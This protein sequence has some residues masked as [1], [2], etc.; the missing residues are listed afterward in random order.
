MNTAIIISVISL[1][2]SVLAVA[3]SFW[4]VK[5]LNDKENDRK[6]EKKKANWKVERI[7]ITGMKSP[8][9]VLT[10][11]NTGKAVAT[12]IKIFVN[13]E[14]INLCSYV[15]SDVSIIP[16]IGSGSNYVIALSVYDGVHFPWE[17]KIV[18]DD[19]YKSE[20]EYITSVS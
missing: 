13:K 1:F 19:D 8:K 11:E 10:I 6:E 4:R 7:K 16:Y 2:L 9:D 15:Y 18:W 17:V 3:L 12:N 5:I 14:D 20:R